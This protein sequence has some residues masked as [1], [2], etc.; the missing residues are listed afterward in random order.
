MWPP[1]RR[2]SCTAITFFG[3]WA[4]PRW[5]YVLRRSALSRRRCFRAGRW[6]SRAPAGGGSAALAPMGRRAEPQY[7]EETMELT[8]GKLAMGFTTGI[9]TQDPRFP[10]LMVWNALFGGDLTSKLFLNVR[11]KLSL[12]YYVLF[13]LWG[14]GHRHGVLG[15]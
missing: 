2:R 11:E 15:H 12:C 9:T 10:A 14:Q 4:L 5:S 6:R 7:L 8:Q 3:C 1:S 13:G